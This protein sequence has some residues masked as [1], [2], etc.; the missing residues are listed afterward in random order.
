MG[1][2]VL[3]KR[4]AAWTSDADATEAIAPFD[5]DEPDLDGLIESRGRGFWKAGTSQAQGLDASPLRQR[6]HSLRTII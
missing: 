6:P 4:L 5:P 3:K 2:E 1:A